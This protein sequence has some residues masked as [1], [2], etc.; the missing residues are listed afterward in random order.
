MFLELCLLFTIFICTHKEQLKKCIIYILGS[1]DLDFKNPQSDKSKWLTPEKLQG[2][3]QEFIKGYP[4][5]SIEDPFD[6][7]DWAAWTSMTAA[8]QIQIVGD[9]LTVTNP[10]RIQMAVDKKACNCLLL[11]VNQIGSVTESIKAH[12]LAKANGWG[13]M[14][15]HRLVNYS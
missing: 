3:Y 10:K 8:T 7:D 11:K 14:V 2:L 9:D 1:Y 13:T 4:I 15:S 12:L 5:V 6:Q